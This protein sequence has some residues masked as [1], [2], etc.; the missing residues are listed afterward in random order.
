MRSFAFLFI[1]LLSVGAFSKS[2]PKNLQK[3][4]PASLTEQ[5]YSTKALSVARSAAVASFSSVDMGTPMVVRQENHL[6]GGVL[7]TVY[8]PVMKIG[9]STP[10]GEIQ[11]IVKFRDDLIS[12]AELFCSGCFRY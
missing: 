9:G 1:L 7:R 2:E 4:T 8:V 12:S 11:Y 5:Q 3:R 10:G 6:G